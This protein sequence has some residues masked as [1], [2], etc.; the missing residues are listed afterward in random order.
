MK[1]FAAA[2]CAVVVFGVAPARAELAFFA[3]GRS[4]SITGH[5]TDGESLVLKLRNGGTMTVSP[6]M[7][8]NFAPDEVPWPE[9]ADEAP[10]VAPAPL[11]PVP[12]GEII[13]K[14]SQQQGVDAKLVRAVIQVESAYNERARSRKGAKG[15]MQLMPETARQYSV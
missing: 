11:P 13:D 12:Y 1:T 15:L 9:P 6:A 7:I 3:N 14:Y 2:V 10:F 8:V 4:M 5:A